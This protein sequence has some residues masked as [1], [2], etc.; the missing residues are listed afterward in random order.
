[1]VPN[2]VEV[3]SQDTAGA[4]VVGDWYD[5]N[6]YASPPTYSGAFMP[7]TKSY[8]YSSLT[9]SA[10]CDAQAAVIGRQ[11][12]QAQLAQRIII[13]MDSRVEL[14]DKVSIIDTRGVS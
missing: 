3:F 1:M 6:D 13:P 5:P 14:Y 8:Y 10:L 7:V 9:T 2:H 11:L 4:S 12:K